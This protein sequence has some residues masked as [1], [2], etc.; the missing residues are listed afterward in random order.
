MM[1]YLDPAALKA[2]KRYALDQNTKVH[3]LL[4]DAV[5]AWFRSHGLR[6]PVRVGRGTAGAGIGPDRKGPVSLR[7]PAPISLTVI[8]SP[9]CPVPGILALEFGL[10]VANPQNHPTFPDVSTPGEREGAAHPRMKR[11]RSA[12]YSAA[13]ELCG[14]SR[15]ERKSNNARS[16][17]RTYSSSRRNITL[18]KSDAGFLARCSSESAG[19]D[20]AAGIVASSLILLA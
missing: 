7:A 9:A 19:D 10:R 13:S 14:A 16:S 1:L 4:L 3:S 5:E 11:Q 12:M 15:A 18:P 17:S 6:E 8:G 20:L 2:L